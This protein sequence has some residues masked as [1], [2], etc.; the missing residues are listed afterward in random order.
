MNLGSLVSWETTPSTINSVWESHTVSLNGVVLIQTPVYGAALDTFVEMHNDREKLRRHV[1]DRVEAAA[2]QM[3]H[4]LRM[5]QMDLVRLAC[6]EIAKL[7]EGL[8]SQSK[9]V[10]QRRK[11]D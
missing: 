9:Y 7:T 2:E 8:E 6:E 5:G 4:D 1:E 11:A 10:D 3:L